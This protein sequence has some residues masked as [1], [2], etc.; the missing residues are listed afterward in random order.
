MPDRYYLHPA[1]QVR[2]DRIYRPTS[3]QALNR[4]LTAA[5]QADRR[6]VRGYY[7]AT[8]QQLYRDGRFD[9]LT[10]ERLVRYV[11]NEVWYGR[12]AITERADTGP[13]QAGAG[14]GVG[15]LGMAG[16]AAAAD[17]PVPIGDVIAVGILIVGGVAWLTSTAPVSIPLPNINL[18]S[19]DDTRAQSLE[20][21][22]TIAWE[23][24]EQSCNANTAA[25]AV[26]RC[27]L[28]FHYT[29]A[30]GFTGIN[31]GGG[32]IRPN[33]KGF[34]YATWL[35]QSPSD[36]RTGLTFDP[37]DHGKGDYVIAFTLR[38]GTVFIPGEQPNELKHRG[39][40]RLGRHADV[41]YAGPNP[42]P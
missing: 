29:N 1:D 19:S 18:M 30:E 31:V 7:I 36:V 38:P 10:D 35:P 11:V 3:R 23:L 2:F 34:V 24:L 4:G 22:E 9:S 21:A 16:I 8:L 40:L 42:L 14:A 5:L 12:L 27:T 6:S 20:D 37:R 41:L 17:G 28:L 39:A 15:V 26:Q 13:T 32:V 25:Q 33:A